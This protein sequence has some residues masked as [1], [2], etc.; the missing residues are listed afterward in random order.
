MLESF[1]SFACNWFVCLLSIQRCS[2]VEQGY[3]ELHSKYTDVTSQNS[4][5]EKQVLGLQR[6][7][8][9]ER[10]ARSHGSEH[11]HTLESKLDLILWGTC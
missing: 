5:L 11:L 2:T 7:V 9:D 6:E 10:K 8:D 3:N 1:G 4:S